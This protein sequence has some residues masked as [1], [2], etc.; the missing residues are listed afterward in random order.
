MYAIKSNK[1]RIDVRHYSSAFI[2]SYTSAAESTMGK[3]LF[4]VPG[5][6]FMMTK[7]PG[8]EKVPDSEWKVIEAI[9]DSHPSTFNT[10]TKQITDGPL[11][12]LLILRVNPAL[13]SVCIR[14]KLLGVTR[15]YWLAVRFSTPTDIEKAGREEKKPGGDGD[16]KAADVVELKDSNS[17]EAKKMAKATYTEEE[18]NAAIEL[19]KEI[20]IHKAAKELGLPWQAVMSAAKKAGVEIAPKVVK[21]KKSKKTSA[22]VSESSTPATTAPTATPDAGKNDAGKNEAGKNDAEKNDAEKNDAGKDAVEEKPVEKPKRGRKKKAVYEVVPTT[23][24]EEKKAE[25]QEEKKSEK[26]GVVVASEIEIENAVLR[27]E[28]A[29]LKAKIE[30]LQKALADLI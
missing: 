5:Y 26:A 28:N 4:V 24:T 6:I 18:I 30:K 16:G 22:Q 10:R 13:K 7:A 2:P 15:D 9:S 27:S 8:A 20:G 14:A 12:G 3:R 11:K 19:A 23:P 21:P 29:A 17:G 25:K 1:E